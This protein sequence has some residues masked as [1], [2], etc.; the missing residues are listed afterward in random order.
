MA[1]RLLIADDSTTIQRV[2]ERTFSPDEFI[3]TFA[4][5]GEEAAAVARKIKPDLVIADIN[6]PGKNGFEVCEEIRKD[7][8]LK[9]TPVLLL[10][11]ILDDF[12]EDAS[13]RVGADGFI[14]KPFEANAAIERVRDALTRGRTDVR[15]VPPS[16][17]KEE[18]EI[19]ELDQ[20]VDEA[21]RETG[22]RKESRDEFVLDTPLRELEL[23]L[24]EEF[25]AGEV[26]G[27]GPLSLDIP[28][29]EGAVGGSV[30]DQR[31]TSLFGELWS[32]TEQEEIKG[33]LE[34]EGP[35]EFKDTELETLLDRGTAAEEEQLE[36]GP[37]EEVQSEQLETILTESASEL[38]RI[39]GLK[40]EE[41]EALGA[42]EV[43]VTETPAADEEAEPE[44][45]EEEPGL[46]PQMEELEE[47]IEELKEPAW[48]SV[49]PEGLEESLKR[50]LEGMADQLAASLAGEVRRAV[51]E[52]VRDIVPD[53]VRREMEKSRKG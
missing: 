7:P 43:P 12:D 6:M 17:G 51:E 47:A 19:L 13:K 20:V 35:E 1:S 15:A 27:E 45:G 29:D 18:E 49:A 23:E 46:L 21:S 30:S 50:S 24:E 9:D 40:L 31:G 2:F 38:E 10:V 39:E 3:L 28:S 41:E 52:V 22:A 14:V 16:K 5:N 4:N 25:T 44:A 33:E 37:R 53:I 34:L 36:I 32:E 26:A 48:V 11:G 8:M 42:A